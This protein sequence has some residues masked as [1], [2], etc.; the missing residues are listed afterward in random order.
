MGDAKLVVSRAWNEGIKVF[1]SKEGVEITLGLDD[2]IAAL[3]QE[4]Q[5]PSIKFQTEAARLKKEALLDVSIKTAV[6]RIVEKMKA[7]TSRSAHR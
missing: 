5:L 4:V 6:L 3:Q 1:M 2:L 7:E